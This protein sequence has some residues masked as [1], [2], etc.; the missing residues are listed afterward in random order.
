MI[1][2]QDERGKGKQKVNAVAQDKEREK[3]SRKTEATH[4]FI[5]I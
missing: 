5:E 2:I 3:N 1:R 4:H